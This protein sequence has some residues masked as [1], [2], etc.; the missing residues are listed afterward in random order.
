MLNYDGEIRMDHYGRF[1]PKYAHGTVNLSRYT[2]STKMIIDASLNLFKE[3]TDPALCVRRI[4]ITAC[5]VIYESDYEEST[6]EEQMS[7]FVD[8]EMKEKEEIE[9]RKEKQ[10]QLASLEI[11]KRYGKNAILKGT[12]FLEGATSRERNAQ[13]GGHKA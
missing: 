5:N 7:L 6:H 2:S 12:D 4:N 11:K 10:L 3:I 8:Y 9:L 13:I 1:L